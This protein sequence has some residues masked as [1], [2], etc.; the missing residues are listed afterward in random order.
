MIFITLLPFTFELVYDLIAINKGKKDLNSLWRLPMFLIVSIDYSDSTWQ[1][2]HV[3]TSYLL[4]CFAPFMFFD[5]VLNVFRFRSYKKWDY[6]GQ[7]K[8]YDK[9]INRFNPIFLMVLRG[10]AFLLILYLANVLNN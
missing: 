9:F 5:P 7:T 1:E 2:I 8:D 4:W 3:Q 10:I 6:K